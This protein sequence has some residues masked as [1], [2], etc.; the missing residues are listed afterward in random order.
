MDHKPYLKAVS[1]SSGSLLEQDSLQIELLSFLPKSGSVDPQD[2]GGLVVVLCVL[3]HA[4]DMK[5]LD[6]FQG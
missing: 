3:E 4:L 2:G 5:L 1:W 6:F